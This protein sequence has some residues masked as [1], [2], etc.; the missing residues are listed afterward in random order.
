MAAIPKGIEGGFDQAFSEQ[1][2]FFRQKLNL[3]TDRWDDIL[4]AAHDRAFVV[5]G[6]ARAD[7]LAD[8]RA[9]VDKAIA[10]GTDL[11]TFR[12]DFKDIVAKH[13]W[14]GWTG[15]GS[16]AGVAW[17][18]R[19]IY[20]TNLRASYAAGRYAQLTD[21]DL[22]KARPFWRYVHNDA[23]ASPRPLHKAWGDS[24]LTL[25]ADHEFWQTHYPPNGWGCRCRVTAVT[26]PR[27]GDATEPPDGWDEPT[28]RGTFPG[29]D[30]GWGYAP[31][32]SVADELRGLLASKIETL[33]PDLG[34]ALAAEVA[35][36]VPMRL[37][38]YIQ[39]G[40]TIVREI[41]DLAAAPAD[42]HRALITRLQA[43]VGIDAPVALAN[44]GPGADLVRS[45]SLLYPDAWTNAADALGD[46]YVTADHDR[47]Y[48]WTARQDTAQK[49]LDGFGVM[50]AIPAGTG[51]M[52]APDFVTAVHELAHRIQHALPEL[53]AVFRQLHER[54]TQGDPLEKL[55]TLNP[56][57]GY[58]NNEYTRRDHY[59][60]PYQ[61]KEDPD[62][63]IGP[64]EVMT[65]AFQY[66]LAGGV[67]DYGG[68]PL[69]RIYNADPEMVN[70]VVGLLFKWRSL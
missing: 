26:E 64:L 69:S 18:T 25:P 6:A 70:L 32:Q 45:A 65:M 20:E 22:K 42:W 4:H 56:K 23:V 48:T 47:G 55:A 7:L 40:A 28:S 50:K 52:V 46:L 2:A 44:T 43:E 39:S 38:D 11:S 53:N 10:T 61:G 19:V 63:D 68:F 66:V 37:D 15:D 14:T 12:R 21:P 35:E 1:L 49:T 58:D 27:A 62:P 17:R 60:D 30:P 9:A 33:P 24:H 16:A 36:V 57:A 54:R 3:P 13:G 8:L 41:G 59:V 34:A 5:A 29:I 51:Y 67:K 31:G